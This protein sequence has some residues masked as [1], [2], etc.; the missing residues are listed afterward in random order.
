[1]TGEELHVL[2]LEDITADAALC[3]RE[4]ARA[5]LRFEARCVSSRSAF[6]T[7]LDKFAPDLIISEFS[8]PSGFDGLNALALAR[9]KLPDT[10]FIF[11]S[12]T[13]GEDQAAQAMKRGAADYLLK[14]QL[15]RLPE[16]VA[17]ALERKQL[18]D[19][20]QHATLALRQREARLLG[21]INSTPSLMFI[22][23]IGGRYL[24]ANREFCR[25]FG[26]SEHD[27]IGKTDE[28]VFP[29]DQAAAFR[30][31][32]KQ[33]VAT[34]TPLEFEERA[35]YLDGRHVS[36]VYKFPLIDAA[37]EVV[38]IGGIVTDVTERTK[39]QQRLRVQ[40][41]IARVLAE[42]VALEE[43]T[44][45]LL[46]VT[47]ERM[48]FTIGALWE[49]D[50]KANV[51][52]CVDI[53]HVPAPALDQ[54][55]AKTRE[56]LLR[57]GAGIAGRAW[58]SGAP[59]WIPEATINSA[60]PRAFHAAAANLQENLAFP[61]TV[62]GKITGVVDFFGPEAR[63]P[64]PELLEVFAAIG[65]QI[66]QFMERR[67]QQQK[68]ARLN[69]IYAVLSSI[70]SAIIRL[71]DKQELLEEACRIAVE[72][73]GFGIAWIGTLDPKTLEVI[74]AA[75]AGI[76]SEWIA[77]SRNT[78]RE[79]VPLGRGFV[80]RA[81]R[82]K[83]A[84]FSNDITTELNPGGER[85]KEAVRRGYRSMIVLPLMVEGA[86]VG[87]FALFA[88]EPN[89]FNEAE[90]KPLVDLADD[91]SFALANIARQQKHEKLSRIRMVSSE[92]N[93]AIVRIR[94]PRA[95]LEEACRIAFEQGK[96]E[97][98]WIGT[99]DPEKQE[100]QSVAWAG[101]SAEIV[102]GVTWTSIG[103]GRGAI[104]E[105]TGT[106]EPVVRHNIN[107]DLPAGNLRQ[108]AIEKGYFSSICIPIEVDNSV[109][110]IIILFALGEGF[111][112]EDELALLKEVAANVS[113]ALQSISHQEKLNY[114]AY[115]D[116]LTGLP[117]RSLF[118]DRLEQLIHTARRDKKYAAA[119]FV[120]TERFRHVNDTLGRGAG[121]DYL[122]QVARRLKS[123]ARE[124]D[125]VARIGA[126]CF[127]VAVGGIAQPSDAAHTLADRIVAAFREPLVVGGQ[128]LRVAFKAGIAVYPNDGDAADGLCANAEAA[129]KKAKATGGRY[130]FYQPEMN[131]KVAET[132]L[133]ENK[134]RRAIEEE[135]FVLHYQPK[136]EIASGK[137]SGLE[138]LIRWNDPETGLVP[139]MH[140]IPLLEETGLIL[141][142]GRWA[143]RKALED[144]LKW[145]AEGLQPPRIAVNVSPIQLRQEDFVDIVRNA[146]SE[147]REVP[148]GLDLEITES[149]IMENIEDNIEKLRA[150]RDLG[151][152]IAIDD[153]GTGYSSLGYLARLPVN[154]LKI[155]RS[156]IIT[157][158]KGPDSM[159][160][161]S[162]IISLAHS[163]SLK[164]VAEGVDAEGQS[165][166][167]K[168]LNCDEFQGYLFSKPLPSHELIDLLQ[169]HGKSSA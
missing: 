162:T 84:V 115:N 147:S 15:S 45:K 101:F 34:R 136:V 153:F 127:A 138:A 152:N 37:G 12:G 30:A 133:L 62:R 28:E 80:G 105:A 8:L 118:T 4:L 143:I 130:L 22:K 102:R 78:A 135:Q 161:V 144:Y 164:V 7:A 158:D 88:K 81:I 43:V 13:I 41:A 112:D 38:G 154:A 21:F 95:L 73:G 156:F 50:E 18:R 99:I 58:K 94:E 31:N 110:A 6:A 59:L 24:I 35:H 55:A 54:F 26:I 139:P 36:I 52:R 69:R 75:W 116:A 145:R 51:L 166:L 61:V 91:I 71:R 163:L 46:Q 33:V 89:F 57:P 167:L 64:E 131:A 151:I 76:D 157:M 25:R 120:D 114:L 93:T 121:D 168:L 90:L 107:V 19:E 155:D 83:R 68:I 124:Q 2:I 53:W 169:R 142:A 11:V 49:V 82:E 141:E 29:P 159:A 20:Q 47:C 134:M 97:M 16:V 87:N 146:I 3:Q 129:L 77:Q 5:G 40:H 23:D 10:P 103:A 104:G 65:T 27:I 98:V 123:A 165:R 150:I 149:V 160:I 106:R 148:H 14:E 63:E 48:G 86:A 74:P 122:R 108:E 111:F 17:K 44:S 109:A 140:F 67:D 125:T 66:G 137:I 119:V 92:V 117:N 132:L 1:M 79:D 56:S 96:F 85:R 60:S 32:D 113:L 72:H 39:A 100:V 128:E 9:A 42:A 126:D 70:N